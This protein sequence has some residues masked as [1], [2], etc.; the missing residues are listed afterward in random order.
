MKQP[1]SLTIPLPYKCNSSTAANPRT[2]PV[3]FQ[4]TPGGT[5]VFSIS[6]RSPRIL[7]IASLILIVV[8]ELSGGSSLR[9]AHVAV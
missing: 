9:R 1:E 4:P 2:C 6:H 8:L 3:S 7:A 5:G